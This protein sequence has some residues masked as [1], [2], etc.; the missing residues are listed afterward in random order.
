MI[1]VILLF[2]ML[3]AVM[4]LLVMPSALLSQTNASV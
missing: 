4:L 1:F 3:S 2:V